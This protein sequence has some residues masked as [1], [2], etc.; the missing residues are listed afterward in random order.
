[1]IIR[2]FRCKTNLCLKCASAI[3][4]ELLSSLMNRLSPAVNPDLSAGILSCRKRGD[5]MEGQKFWPASPIHTENA[6]FEV[7]SS[8][9]HFIFMVPFIVTLY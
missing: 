6:T 2:V 8:F 3:Y 1:M 5:D 7:D 4:S 9:S